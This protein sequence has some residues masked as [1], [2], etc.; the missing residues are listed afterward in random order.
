[1]AGKIIAIED[2]DTDFM[3]LSWALQSAGVKNVIERC[4][5]GNAAVDRLL[6]SQSDLLPEEVGLIILDLNIPGVDGR[7]ILRDFRAKDPRRTVPVIVLTASTLPRDMEECQRT[8]AN[9]YVVK[10]LE[11][12]EW[13]SRIG[14][15][16]E[17]WLEAHK[18]NSRKVRHGTQDGQESSV[19]AEMLLARTVEG[20]IIPRFMLA[21]Q[22]AAGNRGGSVCLPRIP[23]AE[24]VAELTRL[25]IT[26][27][28]GV[29]LAFVNALMEQGVPRFAVFKSL[30]QPTTD[31]LGQFR[32]G[33]LLDMGEHMEAMLRLQ[34]LL[35]QLTPDDDKVRCN[36]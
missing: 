31:L 21:F 7:Q 29:A 16:A 22:F 18:K 14:L 20:E 3:A 30:L 8:G 34:D 2:N 32:E 10:P 4:D 11:L 1:M 5:N 25:L 33:D 13:Q 26:H 36:N 24:D 17:R 6:S 27:D 23:S 9:A 12:V 28:V 19:G 35:E 15:L